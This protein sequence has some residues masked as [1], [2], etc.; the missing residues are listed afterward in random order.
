M[1]ASSSVISLLLPIISEHPNA[2]VRHLALILTRQVFK[3]VNS[4]DDE[5]KEQF[6][7]WLPIQSFLLDAL[8][9]A[10]R[11]LQ[12]AI[13]DVIEEFASF[14]IEFGEWRELPELAV[15]LINDDST[16]FIGMYLMTAIFE[17]LPDE[18]SNRLKPLFGSKAIEGL[19]HRDSQVR[20]ECLRAIDCLLSVICEEDEI[21]EFPDLPFAVQAACEKAASEHQDPN[22]CAELFDSVG[23]IFFDRFREFDAYAPWFCDFAYQLAL[24]SSIALVIRIQAQQILDIAPTFLPDYFSEHTQKFLKST[25]QLSL[26]SCS[27]ARELADYQF[28]SSFLG[29]LPSSTDSSYCLSAI[30]ELLTPLYLS[31]GLAQQVALFMLD[32]TV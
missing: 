23:A 28:C 3:K 2:S 16:F 15:R 11:V 18:E 12:M 6:T 14:V 9:R 27:S 29:T 1:M 13:V 10:P 32:F 26:E 31:A 7:A 4:L 25:I 8:E 21:L 5:E 24:N 19:S 30:L 22:E 20:I 17:V